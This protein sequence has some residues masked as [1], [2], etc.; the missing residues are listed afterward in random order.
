MRL[1]GVCVCGL[2]VPVRP[3]Y[4]VPDETAHCLPSPDPR[5]QTWIKAPVSS[6]TVCGATWQC[7]R[8]ARDLTSQ[9]CSV[10]FRPVNSILH[11]H[12]AESAN[13]LKPHEAWYCHAAQDPTAPAYGLTMVLKV[14][15]RYPTAVEVPLPKLLLTHRQTAHAGGCRRQCNILHGAPRLSH[16]CWVWGPQDTI[17]TTLMLSWQNANCAEVWLA[18]SYIALLCCS[19]DFILFFWSSDLREH[20]GNLHKRS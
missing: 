2:L 16:T 18:W 11:L 15:S 10:G 13:T 19:L 14:S 8:M 12:H 20:G 6:R 3:P 1:S 5:R 9:M 17:D 4:N 7:C